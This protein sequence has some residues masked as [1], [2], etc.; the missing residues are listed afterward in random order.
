MQ[1]DSQITSTSSSF[2]HEAA[3]TAAFQQIFLLLSNI[4]LLIIR[5]QIAIFLSFFLE[6]ELQWRKEFNPSR[7]VSLR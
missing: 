7:I 3:S 6:T 5:L 1:K 4:A 2:T